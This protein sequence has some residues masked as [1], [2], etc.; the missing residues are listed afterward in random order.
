MPSDSP[1]RRTSRLVSLLFALFVLLL[2]EIALTGTAPLVHAANYPHSLRAV[3][4]E[5]CGGG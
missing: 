1:T 5:G 3:T 4:G 2:G